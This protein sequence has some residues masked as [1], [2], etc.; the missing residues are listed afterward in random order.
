M[1]R[2][3]LL[4]VLLVAAACDRDAPGR[5]SP[6][7]APGT[8]E[9][10]AA[11][12]AAPAVAPSSAELRPIL[13]GYERARALLVDD[14]TEGLD[15]AGG[16]I[17]EAAKAAAGKASGAPKDQLTAI[18]G[19]AQKLAA[20]GDVAAARLAYGE[21]SQPLVE[22]V[23]ADA[24]LREQMHLFECPMVKGYGRWLQPTPGIEN[25]YM[26][27]EMLTCGSGVSRK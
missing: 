26:G 19:A 11:A 1:N 15:A 6:P 7:A 14:K 9:P 13:A 5:S 12:P 17:G 21:V 20:A 24:E 18:A 10:A 8:A 23:M 2:L 3:A 27:Q 4:S 22:L 16:E 25:P